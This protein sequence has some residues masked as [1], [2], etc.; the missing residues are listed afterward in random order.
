MEV[1]AKKS[2]SSFS[3]CAY[4]RYS[5]RVVKLSQSGFFPT[6]ATTESAAFDIY[7]PKDY[8]ILPKDKCKIPTDIQIA[9]PEGTA[10]RI[11][12][13]SGLAFNHN[14]HAFHG[15]IDGDFRGNLSVLLFNHGTNTY[16]IKKGDRIA[17]LLLVQISKVS[18]VICCEALDDINPE[19]HEGFGSTGK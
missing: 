12:S 2:C 15:T 6:K 13:R 11:L 17:Q 8:D 4:L 14:I 5:L 19:F 1:S 9:L 18:N 10:G 3:K 16:S 7:S